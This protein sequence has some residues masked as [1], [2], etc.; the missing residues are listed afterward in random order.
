[1]I[2]ILFYFSAKAFIVSTLRS[3]SV[4]GASK[5]FPEYVFM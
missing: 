1:M 2:N 5:E 4:R 3:T